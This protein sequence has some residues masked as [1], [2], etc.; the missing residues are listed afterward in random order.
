MDIKLPMYIMTTN[1]ENMFNILQKSPVY[2][3]VK[4]YV[5][6]Y[7]VTRYMFKFFITHYIGISIV[8]II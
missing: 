3:V 8:Y 4:L 6:K 7:M 2:Y 1:K 5:H